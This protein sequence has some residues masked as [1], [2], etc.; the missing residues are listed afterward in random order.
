MKDGLCQVRVL[1]FNILSLDHL[2]YTVLFQESA[3][4]L[5]SSF[6]LYKNQN[7]FNKISILEHDMALRWPLSA[8]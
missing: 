5:L 7:A 6:L 3:S 4:H 1:S 2:K 8:T